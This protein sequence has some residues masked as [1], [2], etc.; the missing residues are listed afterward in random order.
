M[1]VVPSQPA[2]DEAAAVAAAG[3]LGYPVVVKAAALAHKSDSG[4]VRLNLGDQA[5]V[6]DAFRAAQVVGGPVLVQPYRTGGIELI[7]GVIRDPAWG[8]ML[9][10]G[11]GGIW[12]EVLQDAAL[13]PLPV[14]AA[15]IECALGELRGSAVLRGARG[16]PPAD[17]ARVAEVIAGIAAVAAA[18]GDRLA[19]L[20][21]NPLLVRGDQVEAL[22]ALITWRD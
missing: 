15:E 4:G 22:D 2:A 21:V 5:A 9:A 10:V 14:S 17:L 18:L 16:A 1:P 6:R 20:E 7:T 12:V 8:L 11:L 13:R 3:R 19:A